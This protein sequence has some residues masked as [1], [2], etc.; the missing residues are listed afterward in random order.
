[1]LRPKSARRASACVLFENSP[2][3]TVSSF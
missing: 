3:Q 2:E 1:V